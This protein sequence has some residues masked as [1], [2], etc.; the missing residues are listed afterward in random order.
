[1][2]SDVETDSVEVADPFPATV[3]LAGLREAAGSAGERD[4]VVSAGATETA[5]FTA[6]VK[7]Y[8]L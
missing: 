5:R 2:R 4:A 7:L 3:T 1:M 8:M 6:P